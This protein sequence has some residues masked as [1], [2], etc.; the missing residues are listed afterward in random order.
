MGFSAY[1]NGG[2]GANLPANSISWDD[3]TAFCKALGA[4]IGK[5]VRLPTEAEWEYAARAGTS[6]RFFFGD[7]PGYKILPEYAWIGVNSGHTSAVAYGQKK[8]NPWG[9]YDIYGNLWEWTQDYYHSTYDGAPSDGSAV[10][11]PVIRIAHVLRGGCDYSVGRETRSANRDW[12]NPT[13]R[14]GD[15]GF[16]VVVEGP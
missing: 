2:Q 4:K 5:T 12:G 1:Q 16:R 9:L 14:C 10:Q 11:T 7:D 8:P 3:A 15:V 13:N 6:T